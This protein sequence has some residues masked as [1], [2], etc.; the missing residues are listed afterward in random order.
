[1]S[2]DTPAR[3]ARPPLWILVVVAAAVVFAQWGR[4]DN[5]YTLDDR[6]LIES[7]VVASWDNL[8]AIFANNAMFAAG[9]PGDTIDTYRPLSIATFVADRTS[10]A[11][12]LLAY[13]R[14]NLVAHVLV[15]L[16]AVALAARLVPGASPLALLAAGLF[17]GLHPAGA[18]AHVW[19]NG[20][21]D[22]FMTL[23]GLA[24]LVAFWRGH[25]DGLSC[26]ARVALLVCSG[27]LALVACLFKETWLL[28]WPAYPVVALAAAGESWR[29][30]GRVGW[31]S[32]V[33][34]LLAPTSGLA[35]YVAMRLDVL[36][37]AAAGESGALGGALRLL[38]PVWGEAFRALVLPTRLAMRTLG[39]DF[40]VQGIAERLLTLAG[41]LLGL[42]LV[43]WHA[44]RTRRVWVA[45]LGVGALLASM[46]PIALLATTHWPG[47]N[48]YLYAGI[49]LCAPLLVSLVTSPPRRSV[50]GAVVVAVAVVFGI[51]TTHAVAIYHD[52]GTFAQAR[53]EDSPDSPMGWDLMGQHALDQQDFAPAARLFARAV[54]LG[55]S[56]CGLQE[57]KLLAE[58]LARD[59]ASAARTLDVAL[60]R[61][62]PTPELLGAAGLATMNRDPAAAAGHALRCIALAPGPG[63]CA[64]NLARWCTQH[65]LQAEFRAAVR[66]AV[67][68]DATLSPLAPRECLQPE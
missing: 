53:I 59:E 3:F 2:S 24:S 58:V 20:R 8:P 25:R 34:S 14:T 56:S 52:M 61:C 50:Q 30:A 29:A 47:F 44:A 54:E 48:R 15:T 39:H 41:F 60:A 62:P 55:G 40:A 18:E 57:R 6:R 19:I 7:P 65:P 22:V 28:L 16:L 66:A 9:K 12:G 43:G 49:A 36:G 4:F 21:S 68:A 32:L 33:V 63:P 10:G 1:M 42:G 27:A 17:V 31:R 51:Q 26:A 45:V 46:A 23:A 13:H 38:F 67:E 37:G 11:P 5:G 35:V 64:Q